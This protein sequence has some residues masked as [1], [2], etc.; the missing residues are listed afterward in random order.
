MSAFE[1]SAVLPHLYSAQVVSHST[2]HGTRTS[3][4][5]LCEWC[6]RGYSFRQNK[7]RHQLTCASKK[8]SK[9]LVDAGSI[10]LLLNKKK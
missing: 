8:F 7:I 6:F 5:Y 10:L 2:Q 9:D 4:I 3:M 1:E